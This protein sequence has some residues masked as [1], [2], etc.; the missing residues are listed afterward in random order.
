MDYGIVLMQTGYRLHHQSVTECTTTVGAG[1]AK[2][3]GLIK[4]FSVETQKARTVRTSDFCRTRGEFDQ[5]QDQAD[6]LINTI[7]TYSR[8]TTMTMPKDDQEPPQRNQ[9]RREDAQDENME[10][11]EEILHGVNSNGDATCNRRN[12][13]DRYAPLLKEVSEWIQE[14]IRERDRIYT[15]RMNNAILLDRLAMLL[16]DDDGDDD[17]EDLY[18]TLLKSNRNTSSNR[19]TSWSSNPVAV[20]P[21]AK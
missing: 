9:G 2:S 8:M 3:H 4:I 18:E 7:T 13:E 19:D 21:I 6:G 12:K 20:N 5:D 17:D 16:D 15:L 11:W 14:M 10:Q 1:Q